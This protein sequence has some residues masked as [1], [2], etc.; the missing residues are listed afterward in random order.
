MSAVTERQLNVY[1][2]MLLKGEKLADAIIEDR[3]FTGPNVT[4]LLDEAWNCERPEKTF[5]D[6]RK[7]LKILLDRRG[8]GHLFK[9]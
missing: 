9:L 5:T 7:L 8:G 6:A 4:P 1:Q 3:G 2:W